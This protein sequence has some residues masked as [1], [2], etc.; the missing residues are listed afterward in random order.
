MV[1]EIF[2]QKVST[3]VFVDTK[4][5]VLKL[6]A[7]SATVVNPDFGY[8]VPQVVLR[9]AADLG[10]LH[11]LKTGV[12][13][14]GYY[15]FKGMHLLV[16]EEGYTAQS[17]AGFTE[18]LPP[19]NQSG[20]YRSVAVIGMAGFPWMKKPALRPIKP[21][22]ALMYRQEV[23]VR[24]VGTHGN[25]NP[26]TANAARIGVK[27]MER[28]YPNKG[29]ILE[30]QSDETRVYELSFAPDVLKEG[31][32]F[33]PSFEEEHRRDVVSPSQVI[34][35]SFWANARGD[36]EVFL[37]DLVR[38]ATASEF[39]LLWQ[40]YVPLQTLDRVYGGGFL[41]KALAETLSLDN[42]GK[43]PKPLEA[44]TG[45]I[46]KT[47]VCPLCGSETHL[48]YSQDS[49]HCSC[50]SRNEEGEIVVCWEGT[51]DRLVEVAYTP[52]VDRE[53]DS[54][55]GDWEECLETVAKRHGTFFKI[56]SGEP[57]W[58][59]KKD[60]DDLLLLG[61]TTLATTRR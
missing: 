61:S 48:G 47:R 45:V 57:Q 43:F 2:V 34:L 16:P 20:I 21:F 54:Q 33:Q 58:P 30:G 60:E 25:S 24:A 40:Q 3:V 26:W 32:Y 11:Q 36:R 17:S 46:Q 39:G 27:A 1:T 8:G 37:R 7:A 38:V 18:H 23:S 5:R 10:T 35:A 13:P 31:G 12:G 53:R 41:E 19:Y 9:F 49:S 4:T 15:E 6:Y 55:T 28:F 56:L 22:L 44:W 14:R 50:W 42:E 59:P 51:P 29:F 52:V